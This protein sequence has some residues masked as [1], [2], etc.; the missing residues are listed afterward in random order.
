MRAGS[1]E[2]VSSFGFEGQGLS[3]L[4]QGFGEGFN[5]LSERVFLSASG[6]V[7]GFWTVPT[8]QAQADPLGSAIGQP[9]QLERVTINRQDI[10]NRSTDTSRACRFA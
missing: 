10:A 6:T 7:S 9:L 1:A 8:N 2:P 4:E 3:A 5:L